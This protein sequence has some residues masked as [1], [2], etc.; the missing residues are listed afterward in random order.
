MHKSIFLYRSAAKFDHVFQNLFYGKEKEIPR[1]ATILLFL[2]YRNICKSKQKLNY[3]REK[4]AL[5]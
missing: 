2:E 3:K 4:N 5:L 1:F